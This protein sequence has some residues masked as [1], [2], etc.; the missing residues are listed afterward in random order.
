MMSRLFLASKATSKANPTTTANLPG[1]VK[2]GVKGF[3]RVVVV[4][5]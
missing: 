5:A 4:Q 2:A 3:F 1:I